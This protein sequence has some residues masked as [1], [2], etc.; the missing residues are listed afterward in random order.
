MKKSPHIATNR[1]LDRRHFLRGAGGVFLGLP[2]LE[3]M[4]PAFAGRASAAE[5]GNPKRFMAACAGLGFH[6]PYLFPEKPGTD[7]SPTPYLNKLEKHRDKMTVFSGLSHPE[8]SGNNG[9][10]SSM[11][12]L[13]SAKRP[14]LA[15]FKNTISLDQLIAQQIGIETRFPYLALSS[16]GQSLSWT[17]NGVAIPGESSPAKLFKAMF[18]DG[19]ER[20]IESEVHRFQT[21]RSILDT[22]LSEAK[23]LSND[24]GHR[25]KEKLDEYLTSVRDLEGRLQQSEGWV[26]RPKPKVDVEPPTDI[27]DRNDAINK[28]KLMYDMIVLALQSDSTRTITYSLGGM[29]A[30]PSNLPG[31]K[32]DWHNLSHHGRDEE[33]INELKLIE[34]A[35]FSAFNGFLDRLASIKEGDQSLLDMTSVLFGSNLGNASSHDWR[36]LP[37]IVAGGGFRH[38]GYVAHDEK[39][40]TPLANLFVQLGQRMD[41]ETDAFGSSTASGVKGLG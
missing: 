20:E 36:N 18:I 15:G 34:E 31:V 32:T 27:Q 38:G 3:A 17:S 41:L 21:G 26:T 14:G 6:A 30:V 22:V 9:H 16:G 4:I 10:A 23:K 12:W 37:I 33:K 25:D 5:A 28:Q 35:E 29:N 13:T 39:D 24:L 8:Q 7:Y 19:T 40:N 2:M 1:S 11:T